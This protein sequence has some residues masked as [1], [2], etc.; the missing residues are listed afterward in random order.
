MPSFYLAVVHV[1]LIVCFESSNK[2]GTWLAKGLRLSS[3]SLHG[4]RMHIFS[5]LLENFKTR[6]TQKGI[7]YAIS[8]L[9]MRRPSSFF[10]GALIC[11]QY[12]V[13]LAWSIAILETFCCRCV[14]ITTVNGCR[15]VMSFEGRTRTSGGSSCLPLKFYYGT[16]FGERCCKSVA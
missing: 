1:S 15:V 10:A 11:L 5:P 16:L 3:A 14:K 8:G 7:C 6:T 9:V 2:I 12:I 4:A 13:L